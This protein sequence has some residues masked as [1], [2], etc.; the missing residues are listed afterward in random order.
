MILEHADIRMDPTQGTAWEVRSD[1][2]LIQA[3][4][5]ESAG[6]AQATSGATFGGGVED[7]AAA[8]NAVLEDVIE[9]AP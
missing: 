7:D 4:L 3:C 8:F 6:E 9:E 5:A 2:V 1:P